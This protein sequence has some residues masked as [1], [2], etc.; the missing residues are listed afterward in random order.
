MQIRRDGQQD[1]LWQQTSSPTPAGTILPTEVV[2]VAIVG[3]GITGCSTAL[4]LAQAGL[5]CALLEAEV[6]GF[7]TTG[8][9]TAHLN[10]MLDTSYARLASSFGMDAA[11]LVY[12]G[13][14]AALDHVASTAREL[15]VGMHHR[16]SNGSIFSQNPAQTA[17]LEE[18]ATV[19]RQLGVE[20]EF[21]S[22][23]PL[24][25]QMHRVL[26]I[27]KQAEIH[28]LH[29][30]HAQANRFMELGGS[31]V[32]GCRVVAVK[33]EEPLVI[34]TSKGELRAKQLIY[35]TH[36]PPGVNLLHFRCAP[37]R[38]YALAAVLP[39]GRYPDGLVY[40]ME[41]PY[42]YYRTHAQGQEQWLVVGGE[43][44]KTGHEEDT[45]EPLQRLVDHVH[46]LYGEDVRIAHQWSS[47]YF[48][49]TDGLPYIGTLPGHD[50][51]IMVA[52]GFAGN[53]IT[54]GSLAALV[55]RDRIVHGESR[56]DGLFDP[57]R[58]SPVAG[59]TEFV[60]EN[61]DVVGHMISKPFLAERISGADAIL[62]GEGRLVT[63][64][65]QQMGLYRD[66]RGKF[67]AVD[68][69]CPH[70]KCTVRWNVAELSWDCPCHG[71]RFSV[72]GRLLT[73]PARHDLG[74]FTIE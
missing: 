69:I 39:D 7:G 34:S 25:R 58:V 11:R 6:P 22:D 59:F 56:Y 26:R 30:I 18:M 2:D 49:T 41:V 10:T 53:G 38:S 64:E 20:V 67:H 73:G 3:A 27:A 21:T 1:S 36:I 66:E 32:T 5:T 15:G 42:H 9:T 13:T 8:G 63:H 60:K 62:P 12:Q 28:P 19:A 50:E 68:P 33:N 46:G 40:D 65:G 35:A 52:T 29:Y 37:Y 43:D 74:R 44:H 31:L 61:A 24:P 70:A 47:Q 57:R 45:L 48:E 54:L 16:W 55:F 14:K 72:D 71:S 17:D 23:A 4:E 51:R